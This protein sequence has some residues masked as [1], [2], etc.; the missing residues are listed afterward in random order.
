VPVRTRV[1]GAAT[2]P[3]A[4]GNGTVARARR[5]VLGDEKYLWAL[6]AVELALT[7]HLRTRFR[8]AH[9]G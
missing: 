8:S 1:A 3:T 5:G 9:G 7:A 6:V 4:P 2:I